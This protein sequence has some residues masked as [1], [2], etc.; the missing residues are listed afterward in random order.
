MFIKNVLHFKAVK[1]IV[2]MIIFLERK[3]NMRGLQTFLIWVLVVVMMGGILLPLSGCEKR[4]KAV[5]EVVYTE[6][7]KEKREAE[8]EQTMW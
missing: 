5:V 4:T 8:K 2:T 6:K 1:R 7:P 3:L